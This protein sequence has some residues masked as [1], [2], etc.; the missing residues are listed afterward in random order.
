MVKTDPEN[1]A[2]NINPDTKEIKIT[3]SKEIIPNK[4][5]ISLSDKGK[6]NFPITKITGLENNDKTLV[7]SMD[8]K[9]G[10]EYEF[11]LT[12]KTF[13]SK[14]GYPLKDEKFIVKFQTKAQ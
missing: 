13:E 5:S 9:P 6:E 11:V 3:F 8:L 10:K 1:G 4:Y 2:V 12:N 14:D 7:L